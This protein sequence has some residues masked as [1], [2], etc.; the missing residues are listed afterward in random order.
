MSNTVKLSLF[1]L[2]YYLSFYYSFFSKRDVQA[3]QMKFY[4]KI[5]K[6]AGR[7]FEVKKE[8]NRLLYYVG[9]K[10][11]SMRHVNLI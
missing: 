3:T 10:A 9:A 2:F 5:K 4:L 11:I 1:W 8:E 7:N 6:P